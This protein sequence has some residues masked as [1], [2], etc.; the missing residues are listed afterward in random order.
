MNHSAI[1][2]LI[3]QFPLYARALTPRRKIVHKQPKLTG[4]RL[5]HTKLA[6]HW[7]NLTVRP[8]YVQKLSS[9]TSPTSPTLRTNLAPRASA[10]TGYDLEAGVLA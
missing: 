4:S 6:C 3:A 1:A 2:D 10:K 7:S 5:L 8:K 9:P